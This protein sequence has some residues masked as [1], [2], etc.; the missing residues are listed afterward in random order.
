MI[1]LVCH[2]YFTI[3]WFKFVDSSITSVT[4]GKYRWSRNAL[5]SDLVAS[6]EKKD[7]KNEPDT[8]ADTSNNNI[9]K[10]IDAATVVEAIS[11]SKE[12]FLS[13]LSSP[14]NSS[15]PSCTTQPGKISSNRQY[16]IST[17]SIQG[18]RNHMEDEY[19]VNSGK[20]DTF[21]S[22]MDGEMFYI[23]QFLNTLL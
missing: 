5:S 7:D 20:H 11:T 22:V 6:D 10:S 8:A 23:Y 13:K 15:T 9:S 16:I 1:F 12:V 4:F 3:F 21:V 14:P 17:H 2:V 19:F 18:K